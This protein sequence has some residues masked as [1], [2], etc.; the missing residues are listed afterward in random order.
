MSPPGLESHE[1][2]GVGLAVSLRETI[3]DSNRLLH[4]EHD[5]V[6]LYSHLLC[7]IYSLGATLLYWTRNS[8]AKLVYPASRYVA[9][10]LPGELTYTSRS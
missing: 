3:L 8:G 9:R 6:C 7:S 5:S 2:L 10:A 1:P 4:E